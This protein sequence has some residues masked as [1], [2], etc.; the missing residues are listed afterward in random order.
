M[1]NPILPLWEY[2]PDG[3]PR[4]F[5]NRLYLYGSHDRAACDKF[6]DY[7]LKV[8][9]ADLDDLNNFKCSGV[10][11]STADKPDRPSDTKE[12]TQS[13]L[14]APDVVEKDGK[15]YLYAYIVGSKGCVG[16]ADKP[17]GPFKLLSRYKY[18]EAD[19]GDDG[20]Y[21]D[22]GVLVDD[23]GKVY[24][25]YGFT[26]SNMNEIAPDNMYEIIKGSHM[27]PVIDDTENAP[28]EQRFFEASSP[29]KI[30]GKYY[31]IYSPRKG[32]RLAY[33]ISDSPKGP[34][35]YKGYI[36]DNSVDYPGGNDH[37]S[38]MQVNGQWYIFYHRMTNNTIM[39]RRACVEP[40]EILPDGT[41]PPVEMTSL[42]FEKALD[43]YK[44]TPA[45][46]A[47]VL[48]GGCFVTE[49]DIF[50]RP[51]V[52]IKKDAIIGYKYFDFGDDFS[53]SEYT[54]A[55]KV[56]GQGVYSR[57]DVIIDDYENGEVIGSV[58][59]GLSDGVYKGKVK[60]ITGRH[61]I[62][63]RPTHGVEG[64]TEPYF[65]IKPLFELLEFTFMK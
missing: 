38:L 7:K 17:E 40:V 58:N 57:V 42:G 37:G 24:I 16:V 21:N 52:G 15:Y 62:Y 56:R 35:E 19:A 12:W 43:P 6:C 59:V 44:P 45:E 65:D 11:F 48:K 20:V 53:S 25:Y 26:E 2:I 32:S 13:E 29:R 30:N 50:T 46:I 10:S 18:D 1:P 23:D 61:A 63:F 28:E 36:V 27:R 33:A 55:L 51:I 3:E 5:G 31:L 4:V 60:A 39:S 14:Y 47:C 54:L 22:A 41:I 34:F 64:W 9:Y 49:L 8:W